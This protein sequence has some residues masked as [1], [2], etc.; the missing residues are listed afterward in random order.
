MRKISVLFLIFTVMLMASGNS[1]PAE[2]SASEMADKT[3]LEVVDY[4]DIERY[5]GKWYTIASIPQ[6]FTKGCA[7]GTTAT[8][9]LLDDESVKVYNACIKSDGSI[10]DV[11]GKAWVMD[12]KTNA[13]LKVSFI[14]LI[15]VSFLAGDYW[16]ID[17]GKD[18]EY[19]VVGH[20]NRNY[21]WILSRTK[22]LPEDVLKDIIKRLEAKGYDF[23]DFEMVNQKDF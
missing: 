13:K 1:I 20:P 22:Q 14:P 7:G 17:L 18:Y 9:T 19:A 21:G 16:I 6:I 2:V 4:V 3:E 8:Y 15:K 10:Y 12:K 5:Q 11:E 23:E